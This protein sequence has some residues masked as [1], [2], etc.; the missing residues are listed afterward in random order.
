MNRKELKTSA[1]QSASMYVLS[2]I[3]ALADVANVSIWS[4]RLECI[5]KSEKH[6]FPPAAEAAAAAAVAEQQ[7]QQH[8]TRTMWSLIDPSGQSKKAPTRSQ[9]N[10][11]ERNTR[12]RAL[13]FVS[14]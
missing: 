10:I 11:A 5:G 12:A 9:L 6:L 1:F 8:T 14:M 2:G 7:Q 3:L 4:W 13:R